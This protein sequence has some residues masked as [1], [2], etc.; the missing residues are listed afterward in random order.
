LAVDFGEGQMRSVIAVVSAVAMLVAQMPPGFAQSPVSAPVQPAAWTQVQDATVDAAIV[1]AFKAFPKG[2]DL[3]S[4]RIADIIVKNPKIAVGMVKYVQ[5]TPDLSKD[6]KLAAERGL[7]A[8]LNRLGIKAADMPVK[9]APPPV[10]EVYDYSF[11]LGLLAIAGIICLGLC[12]KDDEVPV[13][14]N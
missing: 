3:L 13:T 2:G 10:A 5:T 14:P 8:A 11:L 4:K 9:A 7:A 1:D 6:Q 12:R